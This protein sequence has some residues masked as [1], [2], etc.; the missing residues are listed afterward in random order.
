M[1]QKRLTTQ[2][3][4]GVHI[5]TLATRINL[6]VISKRQSNFISKPLLSQKSM[7]VKIQKGMHMRNLVMHIVSSMISTRQSNSISRP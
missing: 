2:M 4:K 3:Q 6:S 7:D 5:K 1:S